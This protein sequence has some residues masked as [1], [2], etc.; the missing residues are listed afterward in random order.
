MLDLAEVLERYLT[1]WQAGWNVGSFGAIAEFHQDAG[2]STEID[3]P[4][5]RAT[6]RGAIRIERTEG[7]RPVAWEALSKDPRR[8][9]QGVALCLP[10]ADGARQARAVLTE[11]GPD[12]GAIRPADRGAILFDMGLGQRN[13]DFCVRTPDADLIACLRGAAGLP[14]SESGNPAMG[15]ILAGHPHRVALSAIGRCEVFQKIGGPD[16]GGKSPPGPH[17][18]VLPKLMAARRTHSANTPVPDGWMPGMSLHPGSP[19]MTP[20]GEDRS[21]EP[22]LFAAFQEL[23]GDWGASGLVET[24]ARVWSALD[25]GAPPEADGIVEGRTARAARRIALRQRRRIAGPSPVLAAWLEAHDRG[26]IEADAD[27]PGH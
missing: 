18:H 17:T 20:L 19:V 11:L 7:V 24:K 23:L 16:T 26:A 14:L 4:L 5:E 25:S 9:Q 8:W 1:D 10:D 22:A 27:M 12:E 3:R 21:F 13:I 2:E 15:A 6:A